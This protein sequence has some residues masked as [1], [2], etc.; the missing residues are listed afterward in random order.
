MKKLSIII[1]LGILFT[2]ISFAQSVKVKIE[3]TKG[4]II[5]VLYDE[6]PL[7]KENFVKLVKSNFYNGVLFHRVIKSFMIQGGDPQSINSPANY[8]L[9][10]GGPGYTIPAEFNT[11]FIHKRGALAAARLG[12]NINPERQSSGSQFYIVQGQ[13]YNEVQLANMEQR[14][15]IKYTAD[16]RMEYINN[17]G[18]PHLDFQYTVFG[19]VISGM[20]IVSDIESVETD[21]RDRPLE[22]IKII[23]MTLIE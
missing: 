11:K 20:E 13:R 21:Q 15:G 12:N 19:E 22:D 17:G 9:G 5:V 23:K 2:N 7:H 8:A 1:A 16:Q 14:L 3:T 6:T 18:T 10:N 4:D